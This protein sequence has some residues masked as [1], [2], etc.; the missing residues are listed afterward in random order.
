MSERA[1]SLRAADINSGVAL[2]TDE[3]VIFTPGFYRSGAVESKSERVRI[4]REKSG[5]A[6]PGQNPEA[7]VH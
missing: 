5:H 6:H 4:G 1:T 7:T 2:S 3:G